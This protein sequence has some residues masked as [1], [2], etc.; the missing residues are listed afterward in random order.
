MASEN[1]VRQYLAYWFQLGKKIFIHSG[2]QELL[3]TPV[4]QGERYSEEF[5]KCWQTIISPESG[6]CY[7]DGTEV[8]VAELLTP[9]WDITPC[10]RCSMPVPIRNV[11]LPPVGC[12]CF[13][14]SGWPN[15]EAPSPRSPVD[16]QARLSQIRDRLHQKNVT[17]QT[18]L[19]V[20]IEND[21]ADRNTD[22]SQS[23]CK[24]YV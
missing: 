13:D 8:S 4:I 3:P 21:Q 12:P 6:D 18:D 22:R 7:L 16:N 17:P 24:D 1:Q 11:G 2:H 15:M 10:A 5:E 9:A 23:T 20:Q 14:L 19:S